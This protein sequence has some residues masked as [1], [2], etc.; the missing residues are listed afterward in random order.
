VQVLDEL[1]RLVVT[2]G[3]GPLAYVVVGMAAALDPILPVI[4]AETILVSAAVL[5]SRDGGPW[6]WLLVPAGTL[7]AVAGDNI[8]YWLGRLGGERVTRRLFRGRAGAERLR[9]AEERIGRHGPLMVVA[10]RYIPG[11]RTAATLV[12][13]A[14]GM[15]WRH[16]LL[17]DAVAGITWS[18]YACLLGRVAGATFERST[19]KAILLAAGVALAMTIAVEGARRLLR[20]G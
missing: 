1:D 9:W 2:L 17:A 16:F 11:G 4:P 19:W 20:R 14:L 6:I 13:G 8:M 15:S 7:G 5:S 3:G 12:A 18:A 10:G